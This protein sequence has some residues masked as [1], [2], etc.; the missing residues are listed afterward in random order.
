M[1]TGGDTVT[2]VSQPVMARIE[3]IE[4]GGNTTTLSR[5]EPRIPPQIEGV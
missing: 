5:N 4:R 2:A 1:H 3:E